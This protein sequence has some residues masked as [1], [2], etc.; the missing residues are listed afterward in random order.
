VPPAGAAVEPVR[1][2]QVPSVPTP[3]PPE[4][5]AGVEQWRPLVAKYFPADQ[6]DNAL[7]V[8]MGESSADPT[9]VGDLDTAYPS[10]G[11][12]QVRALPGRPAPEF[13]LHP[14]NNIKYSAE[15]FVQQGWCPWTA[16]KNIGLCTLAI[17]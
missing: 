11:L 12:M 7:A 3:T 8:I 1:T 16:A 9:K 15:M 10:Y 4:P 2:S 5:V 14:E 13:L 17:Y 6:V